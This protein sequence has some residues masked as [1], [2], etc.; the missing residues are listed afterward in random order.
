MIVYK[1]LIFNQLLIEFD[2]FF[3]LIEKFV[4]YYIAKG[5]LRVSCFGE[6]LKGTRT[7]K[8]RHPSL[9]IAAGIVER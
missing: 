3:V 2:V 8:T 9:E 7:F 1:A 6:P 4:V 5:G